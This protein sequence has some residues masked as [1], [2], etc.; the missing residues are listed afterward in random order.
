MQEP[1]RLL[2]NK[3]LSDKAVIA[4]KI[5]TVNIGEAVPLPTPNQ[6]PP[7]IKVFLAA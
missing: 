7:D 6:S 1:Q 5:D 2:V 3:V 4:E